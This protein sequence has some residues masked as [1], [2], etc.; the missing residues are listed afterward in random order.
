MCV[1]IYICMCIPFIGPFLPSFRSRQEIGGYCA[2]CVFSEVKSTACEEAGAA[3][4]SDKKRSE[5]V[6]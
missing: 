6:H 1:R 5:S 2:Y 4:L 3:M